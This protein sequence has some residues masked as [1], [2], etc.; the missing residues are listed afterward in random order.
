MTNIYEQGDTVVISKQG[1]A[2]AGGIMTVEYETT[3]VALIEILYAVCFHDDAA[4]P[5]VSWY[6]NDISAKIGIADGV[7]LAAD[8]RQA[9]Y[10]ITNFPFPLYLNPGHKISVEVAAGATNGKKLTLHMIVRL[11][12]GC[13]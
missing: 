3:V 13:K 4:G 12:P 6:Y 5:V 11:V 8:T 2:A 7:A 10:D 1:A 9:L